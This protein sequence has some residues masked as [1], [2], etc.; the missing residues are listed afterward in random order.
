MQPRRSVRF[1]QR[2]NLLLDRKS[3]LHG[4]IQFIPQA[5]GLVQSQFLYGDAIPIA[6]TPDGLEC[7]ERTVMKKSE[8][9]RTFPFD[10]QTTPLGNGHALGQL[11]F[12][13]RRCVPGE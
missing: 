1:H 2:F 9:L 5:H 12:E 3:L 13:L 6:P 11:R 7:L 10:C 4:T 8:L